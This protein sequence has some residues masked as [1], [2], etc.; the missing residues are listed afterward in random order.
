MGGC[1]PRIFVRFAYTFRIKPNARS[2]RVRVSSG[3]FIC[4]QASLIAVSGIAAQC[5]EHDTSDAKQPFLPDASAEASPL[6]D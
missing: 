6:S 3:R 2:C 4:S 1:S 5:K